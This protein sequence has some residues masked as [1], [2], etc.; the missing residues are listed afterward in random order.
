[1]K[2]KLFIYNNSDI[3]KSINIDEKILIDIKPFTRTIVESERDK[4]LPIYVNN[5][6]Y[7][8]PKFTNSVT[9]EQNNKLTF[10][11]MM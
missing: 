7:T 10:F 9:I 1:M 4:D 5:V 6:H 11:T 3:S 2:R 8:L